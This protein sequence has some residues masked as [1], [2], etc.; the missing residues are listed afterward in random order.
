M[1]FIITATLFTL[2]S[3]NL[4][5]EDSDVMHI[6]AHFGACYVITHVTEVMCTKAIGDDHKIACTV[7]GAALSTAVNVLRKVDQGLPSD[8]NRAMI[9]GAAGTLAAAVIINF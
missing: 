5:A 1:K 4:W 8:S 2:I 9:S 7:A 6:T 3:V